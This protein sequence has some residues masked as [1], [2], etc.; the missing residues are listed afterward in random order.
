MRWLLIAL[1][2]LIACLTMSLWMPKTWY[3][4]LLYPGRRPTRFTVRLNSFSS[5]LGSLGV[6]PS[7]MVSLETRGRRTGKA[8]RVALVMVQMGADNFLVSMLGKNADWVLNV[9][10]SGGEAVLRHGTVE[11]IRLVPV[12]VA[13]RAP[14]LK[15]YVERAPGGRPHFDMGPDAPLEEF[16][17]VAERYPV[18]RVVAR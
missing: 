4:A 7:F 13:Q 16:A 9:Q 8:L 3:R 1:A 15:A 18:F 6:A 5:W 11:Q 12:P 14:I 17:Q 2:V 10:A